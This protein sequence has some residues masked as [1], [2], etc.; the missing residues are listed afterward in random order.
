MILVMLLLCVTGNSQ[1]IAVLDFNAGVGVSQADVDGISA[2]FNTYFSPRG[3]TLVERTQIDKAI[4]EQNFQRGKFT[5]SQMVRIGQ[6]LNVSNVVVGDVNIVAGQ[7]NVDVRV[8]NVQSGTIQTT[9]GATWT[10][11]T[12]YRNMMKSIAEK[13]ANKIAINP[14]PSPSSGSVSSAKMINGHEYVDLGLSVKWAT[15]NVGAS[16]PEDYGNYYAWGETGTKS[17]YTDDNSKT[18]GKQM[19]DIKGNSLYDAARAN[20][21]GTWRLPTKAELEELNNKCTWKWTTQNGVKGY[22]V[23]GPNGNSIFL[24]AAGYRYGSSLYYAGE[25]G[26]FWSS[27]SYE[28]N[29]FGACRLYFGSSKLYVY[30]NGRGYGQSVRP[31]SE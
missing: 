12:S 13:L 5:E 18:Y 20:W 2:I 23:T 28:S 24:P 14:Q 21:G 6:I 25:N 26:Y 9:E 22:K 7:Y 4:D 11:G 27:T 19:Y 17:S 10:S 16:K 3:Y 31:V 30:S 15:C 8:V 1:R 29:S